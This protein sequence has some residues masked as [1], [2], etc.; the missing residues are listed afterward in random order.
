MKSE[1]ACLERRDR[2]LGLSHFE[3]VIVQEAYPT[4]SV[5][6]ARE[7]TWAVFQVSKIGVESR[8]VE[9]LMKKGLKERTREGNLF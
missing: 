8:C 9:M 5:V 7:I 6:E 3:V 1:V 2:I 4:I